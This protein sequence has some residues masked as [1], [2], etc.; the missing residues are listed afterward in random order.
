[1]TSREVEI[2]GITLAVTNMQDMVKF[3]SKVFGLNFTATDIGDARLYSA[4]WQG[5]RLLFCPAEIAKNTAKQNRHQFEFYVQDLDAIKK[6]IETSGGTI[7]DSTGNAISVYD[8][9]MN[10]M[11]F[12]R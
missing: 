11:V 1:M 4:D 10:S 3:Y 9:D 12:T 8:P 2:S 5:R 7:F 6:K